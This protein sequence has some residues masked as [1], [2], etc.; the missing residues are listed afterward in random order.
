MKVGKN[1]FAGGGLDDQFWLGPENLTQH[2]KPINCRWGRGNLISRRMAYHLRGHALTRG[3]R[4]P[5]FDPLDMGVHVDDLIT[6]LRHEVQGVSLYEVIQV[7]RSNMTGRYQVKVTRPGSE[8]MRRNMPF[9]VLALRAVQ[10]H[11]EKA[12]EACSL[13]GLGA[14]PV[15]LDPEYTIEDLD[16]GRRPRVNL[17]PDMTKKNAHGDMPPR[18]LYH[19]VDES[20]LDN[21]LKYGLIPGGFPKKSGRIHTFFNTCAPWHEKAMRKLEGTR[22]GKRFVVA[23]DGEII[24]QYGLRLFITRDAVLSPDWI[25]NRAIIYVYDRSRSHFVWSNRAY[26]V[27]RREYNEFIASQKDSQAEFMSS[28]QLDNDQAANRMMNT[29]WGAFYQLKDGKMT[30]L[31][32]LSTLAGVVKENATR[33]GAPSEELD[34]RRGR[35]ITPNSIEICGNVREKKKWEWRRKD[36]RIT[37]Q[38]GKNALATE[39]LKAPEAVCTNPLCR[40]TQVDGYLLC[41]ECRGDLDSWTTARIATDIVR[42][43][44]TCE[45]LQIPFAISRVTE[46][47]LQA[48]RREQKGNRGRQSTFVLLKTQAKSL[49]RKLQERFGI[50]SLCE[51][52]EVDPFF[53]FNCA[54]GDLTPESLEFLERMARAQL[55]HFDRTREQIMGEEQAE[56]ASK[57]CIVPRNLGPGAFSI[58][59]EAFIVD[60]GRFYSLADFATQATTIRLRKGRPSAIIY[61]WSK[62]PLIINKN[63]DPSV[64]LN[65]LTEFARH[66]FPIYEK[67]SGTAYGLE[68]EG[69]GLEPTQAYARP[70][71]SDHASSRP[72]FDPYDNPKG[73]GKGKGKGKDKGQGKPHTKYYQGYPYHYYRDYHGQWQ[74]RWN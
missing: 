54:Q 38:A 12:L 3:R 47:K 48:T 60:Y 46:R 6:L 65:Q 41:K 17:R 33:E 72:R 59:E 69:E 10:G 9:K 28:L 23:F 20:Y 35:L 21:V 15:S 22:A 57:L 63:V 24:M 50:T 32:E 13:T 42:M 61:G 30:V 52:L 16:A 14:R 1:L 44:K 39:V 36:E 26:S 2:V 71:P 34:Y 70:E 74:W 56:A 37:F 66:N 43:Q 45:S 25:P 73:K 58:S 64:A 68:D 53:A 51:R 67:V 4:A 27:L 29:D 40:G 49:T 7:V 31:T 8:E 18:I 5:N 19:T 11:S 55:P 62:D